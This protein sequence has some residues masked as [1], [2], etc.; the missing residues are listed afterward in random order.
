MHHYDPL[1]VETVLKSFYM[2][3]L[4]SSVDSLE[5]ACKLAN[6]LISILA[7]GGF[8]LT[9]FMSN[10]NEV[11]ASLPAADC[12]PK[13]FLTWGMKLRSV[14]LELHGKSHQIPSHSH[15]PFLLAKTQSEAFYELQHL[16]L[17]HWAW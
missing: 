2:D 9:K 7:Q 3:D 12:S 5:V 4:L 16:S 13:M 8:H 15:L 11:L 6:E 17:I 14:P 10:S 1:T